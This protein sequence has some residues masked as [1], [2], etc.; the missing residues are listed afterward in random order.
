MDW[1]E[2]PGYNPPNG[3]HHISSFMDGI[4]KIYEKCL[5]TREARKN[6]ENENESEQNENCEVGKN[7]ENCEDSE[8]EEYDVEKNQTNKADDSDRYKH[9][10]EF[11]CFDDEDKFFLDAVSNF[12]WHKFN[13]SFD[14]HE[15]T[16]KSNNA[17]HYIFITPSSWSKK[18]KTWILR[19]LFIN[20]GMITEKDHTDRI[21]FLT[22]LEAVF[23]HL[24]N[25]NYAQINNGSQVFKKGEE[26]ILCR[27]ASSKNIASI[28]FD[29]IAPQYS[30]LDV[31]DAILF[32]RVLRS[33]K[34]SLSLDHFKKKV[35]EFVKNKMIEE[36]CDD[37]ILERIVNFVINYFSQRKVNRNYNTYVYKIIWP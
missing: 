36:E 23:Y 10:A 29:L 11:A 31:S 21:L 22:D 7:D 26:S 15:I 13:K 1:G 6:K 24:Q 32:P 3:S 4:H 8:D 9:F 25:Q 27:V 16:Q 20:S 18:I 12:F 2:D 19:P 37:K 17:F 35:R 34:V 30:Q 14:Y 33:E 28:E 5:K